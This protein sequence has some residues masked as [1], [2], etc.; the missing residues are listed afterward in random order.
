MRELTAFVD[1]IRRER[2]C[3][4]KVPYFDPADGGIG[5]EC[6]FVLE[7]PGPKAVVSGFVSRDNPDETAKNWLELLAEAGVP[8]DRSV[9]W[10]IV[11]WYVGSGGRTR[12]ANS[13]DI[14]GGWPYLL[15]LFGLLH[16]LRVVVLVGRKAQSVTSRTRAARQDVTL[17][18]CPHPSPLFVNRRPGNRGV[19][20]TALQEVAA[21]LCPAGEGQFP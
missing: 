6:L 21:A 18:T 15:Q 10:N 14:D 17:L 7:A 9:L 20:L 12:P 8:R 13:T 19:L 3:G 16:R 5:A 1:R 11:P 2:G 4:E